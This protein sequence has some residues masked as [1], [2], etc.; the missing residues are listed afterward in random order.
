[1][2]GPARI[3]IVIISSVFTSSPSRGD[4]VERARLY[5]AQD[6]HCYGFQI[7]TK[8]I[9]EGLAASKLAK[10]NG[11]RWIDLNCG[12]PIYGENYLALLPQSRAD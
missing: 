12:C 5:K 2:R 3:I 7:A 9:S 4:K 11:A 10:E 1:M 6:E 8:V